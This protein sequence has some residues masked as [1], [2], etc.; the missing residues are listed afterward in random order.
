MS[1]MQRMNYIER[2]ELRNSRRKARREQQIK[3]NLFLIVLTVFLVLFFVMFYHVIVSHASTES[4]LTY[5][6]FTGITVQSGDTLWSIAEE[7]MDAEHYDSIQAY[8]KEV[9]KTNNMHSDSIIAGQL[10]IV[11]YYSNVYME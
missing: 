5:K 9:M 1:I 10:L 11:P 8:I 7:Y 6:Y 3:R 2:R 4:D